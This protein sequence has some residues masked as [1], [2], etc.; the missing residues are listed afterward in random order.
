MHY[1]ADIFPVFFCLVKGSIA[2]SGAL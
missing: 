2:G 1:S